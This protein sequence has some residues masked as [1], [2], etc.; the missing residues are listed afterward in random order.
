MACK[1]F[2]MRIVILSAFVDGDGDPAIT[3][4]V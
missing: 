3:L 2:G 4:W 1:Q